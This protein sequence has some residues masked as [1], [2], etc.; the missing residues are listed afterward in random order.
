[1]LKWVTAL[2]YKIENKATKAGLVY[3]LARK[4][5]LDV[6]Q[7]EIAL[8]NI[9]AKDHILCIG[10]GMCPF[11]AVLFHQLTGAKVTVIDNNED[12][13]QK[14]RQFIADLG[15]SEQIRVFC[16]DGDSTDIMFADYSVVHLALQ[17][18]PME[19]VL[20]SVERQMAPGTR[21]L[22]RRPKNH[23]H[24]MYSKFTNAL[25]ACCPYAVHKSRNIGSTALYIKFEELPMAAAHG[26]AA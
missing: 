20:V 8:A 15:L 19:Q 10:G 7:K 6:V 22:V 16:Q 18:C 11:S 13:I 4:Y 25:F 21:L 5:Y 26:M 12:C 24:S 17:V 23:L 1:M 14:A 3:K 2:T 9:T